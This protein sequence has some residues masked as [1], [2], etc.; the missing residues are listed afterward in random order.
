[1]SRCAAIL[2][3]CMSLVRLATALEACA[4]P[5]I[6]TCSETIPSSL[7][8]L[9]F[10]RDTGTDDVWLN[11]DNNPWSCDC[12]M[13]EVLHCLSLILDYEEL[14]CRYP[15]ALNNRFLYSLNREDLV[16][17]SPAIDY[18]SSTVH[19]AKVG[20]TVTLYCNATGFNRPTLTWTLPPVP[21][22]GTPSDRQHHEVSTAN[23]DYNSTE[24]TLNI[25]NVQM[26]DQGSY[27]CQASNAA[28]VDS[29]SLSLTV[30]PDD[31]QGQ[32]TL[33]AAI[34]GTVGAVVL[35]IILGLIY[36]MHKRRQNKNNSSNLPSAQKTQ[37]TTKHS[38]PEFEED[39]VEYDDVRI[40][41]P[42]GPATIEIHHGRPV[43]GSAENQ[44]TTAIQG[45]ASAEGAGYLYQGLVHE[46]PDHVYT[47]LQDGANAS[48]GRDERAVGDGGRSGQEER[49]QHGP[50]AQAGQT[51]EGTGGGATG[52]VYQSLRQETPD[53]VYTS[54]RGEEA[55]PGD[56]YGRQD[57]AN[58]D[59]GYQHPGDITAELPAEEP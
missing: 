19:Q 6:C 27:T 8:N 28:G 48:G 50:Q 16:C 56:A 5:G 49:L 11:L 9:T 57:I 29:M 42:R 45:A 43:I 33:A 51:A 10:V 47:S 39:D 34:G 40:A 52:H 58:A 25:T 4:S 14:T 54:L 18:I 55:T 13:R 41:E 36:F 2:A 35:C 22:G 7:C 59:H 37:Q 20:E 38:N 15:P 30:I 32:R 44:G 24:S 53:H 46:N 23:L 21:P 3:V 1:M 17:S 12:R 31:G 26:S